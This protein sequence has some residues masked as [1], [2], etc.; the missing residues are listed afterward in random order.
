MYQNQNQLLV[1]TFKF[2]YVILFKYY[3]KSIINYHVIFNI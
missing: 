1:L 3:N 2:I